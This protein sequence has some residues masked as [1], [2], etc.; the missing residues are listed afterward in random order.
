MEEIDRV[1]RQRLSR[2]ARTGAGGG[3]RGALVSRR[4]IKGLRWWMMGLLMLG[5]I[6]NYLT[7]STLAVAA[8]TFMP[9]LGITE[10]E[11]SLILNAFQATIM[12]QPL[13]GLVIDSIGLKLAM[14]IFA[15]SWSLI[16]MAH[17][18]AQ[19]WP[20]FAALRGLLGFA[21]GSANPSG[22]KATAEWFPAKERG[23]AAGFFNIGASF[24]SMLA[25]PLVGF[26]I[27]Y[28]NWQMAFVVTGAI[29]LIW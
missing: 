29:G 28:Y 7:R 20:M 10:V 8:P 5:A 2:T 4:T 23:F 17:G 25:P 16:T 22:M 11:Y 12:L 14:A 3:E 21:E 27:Y 18:L 26:A 1:S 9:D 13:A 24:G 15:T 6:V 19:G